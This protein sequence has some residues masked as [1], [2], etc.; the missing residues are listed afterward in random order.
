MNFPTDQQEREGVNLDNKKRSNFSREK[1]VSVL[2]VDSNRVCCTRVR[3]IPAWRV[4][5]LEPHTYTHTYSGQNRMRMCK[6]HFMGKST[7]KVHVFI[8]Y[9]S[10]LAFIF[11]HLLG[12]W[13]YD[14][15]STGLNPH[16]TRITRYCGCMGRDADEAGVCQCM[17]VP[18][19]C[20]C[21]ALS[22]FCWPK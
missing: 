16:A 10:V 7:N 18:L 4:S 1:N 5:G 9:L 17:E 8:F 19:E 15:P 14:C 20:W 3:T 22:N 11:G 13:Q 12:D 2:D 21:C 6:A